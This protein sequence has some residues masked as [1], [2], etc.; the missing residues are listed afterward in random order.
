MATRRWIGDAPAVA[1]IDTLTPANVVIGDTFTATIN[2]KSITVTAAA[3][4][5]ANVTGL[6]TAAW[7]AS[8]VA[9][10]AEITAVDSTS[11]M[12]L[13]ADTAGKPFTVTATET[14]GG[15][16]DTQTHTQATTT[17]NAGPNVWG[18]VTNWE[19]DVKPVS[20]DTVYIADGA[21]DILYDI[22][23]NGVTLALFIID[24]G[25]TGKIGLPVINSDATIKYGEYRN[26]Y[27]KISATN[28]EIG[29]GDGNG[30]GRIKI[31]LGSAAATAN[32]YNSG[33][34]VETGIPAILL[35]GTHSSN[36]LNVHK[37]SVGVAVFPGETSTIATL[38]VGYKQN[39]AGDSA[40]KC[41][42]GMTLT[43]IDISGGTLVIEDNTTTVDMTAGELTVL[44][45]STHASIDLDGGTVYYQSTGTCAAVRVAGGAVLDFTRDMRGRTVTAAELHA[46]GTIR[47][48]FKS[49]T[50][51]SG[52]DLIG[53]KL[54]GLSASGN[55]VRELDLGSH[56]TITPTAV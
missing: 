16:S 51:S 37:G 33:Q 32:I 49:V 29:G 13:T 31:N 40:V 54:P 50:W 26:T 24:Q 48:P 11:A 28:L 18:T 43:N 12:T 30:S 36:V 25:Y 52:V 2:G 3:A 53:A 35:T 7:N 47:D 4:N 14:N 46:N 45:S 27:L 15:G 56:V 34:A 22:D 21:S 42:D 8:T 6:L 9:E 23:Q 38:G 20:T 17:T 1:Q 10:F 44:G 41:G 55:Q 19:G 5:V 39:Q